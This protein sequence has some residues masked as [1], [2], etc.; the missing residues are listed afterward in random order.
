MCVC[1]GQ[2]EDFLSQGVIKGTN[3]SEGPRMALISKTYMQTYNI[4]IYNIPITY[5]LN[6]INRNVLF[7]A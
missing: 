1:E 3:V 4:Y 2:I 5:L 7:S 6:C